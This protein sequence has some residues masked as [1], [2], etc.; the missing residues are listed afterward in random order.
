MFN[1]DNEIEF[2][3]PDQGLVVADM[4][5]D[6]EINPVTGL[7][8]NVNLQELRNQ[9]PFVTIDPPFGNSFSYNIQ[10]SA[11]EVI[12]SVPADARMYRVTYLAPTPATCMLAISHT[13]GIQ[14]NFT[15]TV[16]SQEGIIINPSNQW[17]SCKDTK[18]VIMK[19]IGSAGRV[20]VSIEFWTQ[21]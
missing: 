20:L 8:R 15:G 11:D 14:F 1:N 10:F 4:M 7:S 9:H 12:Q 17:R 19:N 5:V 13:R 21:L 16:A 2:S 3:L 18:E 6:P